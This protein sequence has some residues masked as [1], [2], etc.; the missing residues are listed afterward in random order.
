MLRK[1]LIEPGGGLFGASERL[2]TSTPSATA[3]LPPR[4]KTIKL[5]SR[6]HP[7][8]EEV[9]KSETEKRFSTFSFKE[10]IHSRISISQT[11][12]I[13][14]PHNYNK[15][16]ENYL[17]TCCDNIWHKT[18]DYAVQCLVNGNPVGFKQNSSFRNLE[19]NYTESC[20]GAA[21]TESRIQINLFMLVVTEL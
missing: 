7:P 9:R 1:V 13:G 5:P 18:S 16:S 17:I 19:V 3:C 6:T 12:S 14:S 11:R 20:I 15:S 8:V 4:K 10:H 21:A 2:S